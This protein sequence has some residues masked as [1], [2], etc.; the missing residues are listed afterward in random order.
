MCR[1]HG[2]FSQRPP[3][4]ILGSGCPKCQH[5]RS[6]KGE[7][8][9][10]DSL[11]IPGLVRQHPMK[12]EGDN[13]NKTIWADGYDPATNTCFEYYGDWWHGNLERYD[14]SLFNKSAGKT[15]GELNRNTLLREDRIRAMGYNL[16]SMW[17]KEWNELRNNNKV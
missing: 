14:S 2:K 3:C 9:W 1:T 13:G 17:E 7:N 4:H 6:S 10:L 15:M 5:K 16:V 12:I 11:G 8:E